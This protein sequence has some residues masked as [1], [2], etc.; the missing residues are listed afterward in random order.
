MTMRA[1][2]SA[3]RGDETVGGR[4]WNILILLLRVS[5]LLL[6]Y[7]EDS[8]SLRKEL[9]DL[10]KSVIAGANTVDDAWTHL[11]CRPR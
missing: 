8:F 6:D 5:L 3:G 10:T 7:A 1:C 9:V 2:G 4:Q 11:S